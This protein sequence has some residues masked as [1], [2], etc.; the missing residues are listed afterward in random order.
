MNWIKFSS[1]TVLW[2]T[3]DIIL[4]TILIILIFKLY[5]RLKSARRILERPIPHLKLCSVFED[6]LRLYGSKRALTETFPLL[7]EALASMVDINIS[8]SL[9]SKEI[10]SKLRG[11]MEKNN[12]LLLEKMYSLYEPVRFWNH[13]LTGYDLEVFRNGLIALE[14]SILRSGAQNT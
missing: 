1:E 12:V 5:R 13:Q 14:R 3:L 6:K 8:K 11:C 7:L 10:L 4:L 2:L 9:T